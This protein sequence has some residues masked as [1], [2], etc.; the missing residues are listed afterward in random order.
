MADPHYMGL[1]N[2]EIDGELDASQ[3]AELARCLLADPQAQ[4]LRGQMRR[5]AQLLDGMGEV[6]PPE[7]L[8]DAVLAALPQSYAKRTGLLSPAW[9]VAAVLA[10]VVV[11]GALLF[12]TVKGPGP[13][14]GAL[15]GTILAQTTTMV[16]SV[17]LGEGAVSGRVS[18]Y[19]DRAQLTLRFEVLSRAP[20][21]VVIA[22]GAHTLRV[23]GL[24]GPDK[25]GG[26]AGSTV[27]LPDFEM[28]GQPVDLTFVMDGR[29]VG[30][31]TLRAPA[32]P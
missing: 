20:V 18:L 10:G 17:S 8:R 14:S 15:S 21:D 32:G 19:R 9:R 11:A 28:H 29:P 6:E 24:G 4:A 2:V 3:R 26:A 13:A 1:I 7:T 16:D 22:S 25:S 12:E 30:K 23:K 31:A 27:P 5:L